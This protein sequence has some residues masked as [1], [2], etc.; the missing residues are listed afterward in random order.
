MPKTHIINP[1]TKRMIGI[2]TKTAIR[3]AKTGALNDEETELVLNANTVSVAGNQ[4]PEPPEPIVQ[5][6]EK[7]TIQEPSQ[8]PK[9]FK[10]MKKKIK[11]IAQ[12]NKDQFEGISQAQADELLKKML[13][14]KLC[15]SK[16]EKTSRTSKKKKVK[17]KKHVVVQSESEESDE[18]EESSEDW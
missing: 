1:N 7:Q 12:E 10:Q 13:Y 15:V 3:L 9:D 18:S 17:K 6:P 2:K 4:N 5:E 8:S 14:E 11:K 16:S